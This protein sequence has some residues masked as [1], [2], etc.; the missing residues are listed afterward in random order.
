MKLKFAMFVLLFL[1]RVSAIY[2][3]LPNSGWV[4]LFNGRDLSGWKTNG[5][6][7]WVVENGTILCQSAANKYG[8]LTTDKTYRDFDLR[9][10]FKGE[11]METPASSCTHGSPE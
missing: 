8:Y 4:T 10:K 3:A 2:A 5:D 11:A 1:F 7:K 9:L 6:E